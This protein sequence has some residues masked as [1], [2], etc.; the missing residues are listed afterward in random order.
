MGLLGGWTLVLAETGPSCFPAKPSLATSLL[1]FI[2]RHGGEMSDESILLIMYRKGRR[3]DRAE[4]SQ[5]TAMYE[6]SIG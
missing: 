2:G 1:C 4:D 6:D 5:H 3:R